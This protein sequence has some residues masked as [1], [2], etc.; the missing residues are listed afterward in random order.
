MTTAIHQSKS[1]SEPGTLELIEAT[2]DGL[3]GF[4][5]AFMSFLGAIPGL[6]PVAGLTIV[7]GVVLLIPMLAIGLVLG[8][9]WGIA[10][11]IVWLVR[12]LVAILAPRPVNG[13]SV[14]TLR[15]SMPGIKELA[16]VPETGRRQLTGLN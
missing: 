6:L 14:R 9:L 8:L 1:V 10:M 11:L 15:T 3:A 4:G 2:G 5:L 16:D 13:D 7:A 12:R